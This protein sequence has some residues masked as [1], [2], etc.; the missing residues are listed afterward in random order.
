[1]AVYRAAC[2]EQRSIRLGVFSGSA[3]TG[4]SEAAL[5]GK[6]RSL[7]LTQGG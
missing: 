1:M 2:R 6:P 4:L 3:G 7:E 5:A